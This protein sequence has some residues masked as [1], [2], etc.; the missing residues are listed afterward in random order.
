MMR[1]EFVKT[2]FKCGY[3]TQNIA[4][5]YAKHFPLH[6]EFTQEDMENAYRYECRIQAHDAR[7]IFSE[8]QPL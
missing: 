4:E 7:V 3:C 6:H 5:E 1:N 2:C 8:M